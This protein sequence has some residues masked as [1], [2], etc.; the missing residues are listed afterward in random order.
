LAL[1]VLLSMA[2]WFAPALVA[3]GGVAPIDAIKASFAA[4]L[5][6][7][8]PIAVFGVL[9][10]VAAVVASLPMMLGWILLMPLVMLAAYVSYRD[11]FGR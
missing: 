6:N 4:N 9:Y 11:V 2:I 7:L 5:K 10:L 3:L 1:S 8:L